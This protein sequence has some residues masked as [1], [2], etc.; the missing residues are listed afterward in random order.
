LNKISFDKNVCKTQP[1]QQI[2]NSFFFL[3]NS[4]QNIETKEK[5][6]KVVQDTRVKKYSFFFNYRM[7]SHPTSTPGSGKQCTSCDYR[8]TI[9]FFQC[10]FFTPFPNSNHE[11]DRRRH[12]RTPTVPTKI[13]T[14]RHH[15]SPSEPSLTVTHK[16]GDHAERSEHAV[17]RDVSSSTLVTRDGHLG[18]SEEGTQS[19]P[20]GRRT[21]VPSSQDMT[22]KEP[23]AESV[24]HSSMKGV[25]FFRG[26]VVVPWTP[27]HSLWV[28]EWRKSMP[29]TTDSHSLT[30]THIIL[31]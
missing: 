8:H 5:K 25:N 16:V 4:I 12:S 11:T 26:N 6:R 2:E 18:V 28:E 24:D 9:N 23:S 14:R 29:Y 22:E 30:H 7:S 20:K 1:P 3:R 31:I 17:K 21:R 19:V 15:Q 27:L 10:L 13:K